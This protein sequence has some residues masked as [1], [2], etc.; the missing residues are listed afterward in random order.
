MEQ[1]Y[2]I[3]ARIKFATIKSES[4][5]YP[6]PV[7]VNVSTACIDRKRVRRIPR[8]QMRKEMSD[9]AMEPRRKIT[10]RRRKK[11]EKLA[12][13]LPALFDR[14]ASRGSI[15]LHDNKQHRLSFE[16]TSSSILSFDFPATLPA[17]VLF[18]PSSRSQH[19]A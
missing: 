16:Q 13:L 11:G 2:P 6:R 19:S 3:V 18:L 5:Y 9:K 7:A 15:E 8:N 14:A 4:K 10:T 12:R 17:L 1:N